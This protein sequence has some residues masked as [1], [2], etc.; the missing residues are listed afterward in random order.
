MENLHF[1]KETTPIDVTCDSCGSEIKTGTDFI[2]NHLDVTIHCTACSDK[3]G[4]T[5]QLDTIEASISQ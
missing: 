2:V 5:E 4:F 1:E 3:M